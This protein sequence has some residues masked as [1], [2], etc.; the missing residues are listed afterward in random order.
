MSANFSE[1]EMV[2]ALKQFF[3]ES[4]KD[5]SGSIDTSELENVLNQ[6]YKAMSMSG[7]AKTDAQLF[8]KECDVSGDRKINEKEFVDFFLKLYRM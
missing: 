6:F 1:G 4:D 3:R 5:G 7:D 8:M 2:E